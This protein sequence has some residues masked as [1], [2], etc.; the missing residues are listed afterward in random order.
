[1]TRVSGFSRRA[2]P[3]YVATRVREVVSKASMRPAVVAVT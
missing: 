2:P 3:P 1:L